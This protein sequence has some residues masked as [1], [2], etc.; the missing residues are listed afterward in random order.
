MTNNI[1]NEDIEVGIDAIAVEIPLRVEM[2][3][4]NNAPFEFETSID[5]V[6]QIILTPTT[7]DVEFIRIET[8]DTVS[9]EIPIMEQETEIIEENDSSSMPF[10][11]KKT[12][13]LLRASMLAESGDHRV[14]A[15]IDEIGQAV[16]CP[17]NKSDVFVSAT[18]GDSLNLI[19]EDVAMQIYCDNYKLINPGD[20]WIVKDPNEAVIGKDFKTINDAKIFVCN[21]EI[22]RLSRLVEDMKEDNKEDTNKEGSSKETTK[23]TEEPKSPEETTKTKEPEVTAQVL[24][25]A[26]IDNSEKPREFSEEEIQ[27]ALVDITDNFTVDRGALKCNTKFEQS[28]CFMTLQQHYKDVSGYMDG[29]SFI[30]TFSQRVEL[31]ESL[32]QEGRASV[33]DRFMKGEMNIYKDTTKSYEDL[34][35]LSELDDGTLRYYYDEE[36]D[37][38]VTATEATDVE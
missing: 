13:L 16:I 15:D 26:V 20:C 2:T 7:K 18:I 22:E 32:T 11:T 1:V 25:E 33:I 12:S 28:N 30:I 23:E 37:S 3:S 14:T 5:E 38:I 10:T 17:M 6:G 19:T 24:E 21:T 4:V 27:K 31:T 9:Y 34:I 8:E 36:S 35:R 29:N